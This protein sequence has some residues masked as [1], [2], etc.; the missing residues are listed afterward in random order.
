MG[1]DPADNERRL[2]AAFDAEFVKTKLMLE[3]FDVI[4][5]LYPQKG[6]NVP[7]SFRHLTTRGNGK[8]E[9]DPKRAE[10]LSWVPAIIKNHADPAVKR[11]DYLEGDGKINT[12][13][14]LEAHDFVVI[15][16]PKTNSRGLRVY[17]LV[18]AYHLDFEGT[19]AT[20]T[21][22]YERREGRPAA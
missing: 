10:R 4:L 5:S 13:L 20:Y 18:T 2:L 8:R 16:R 6:D 22:K 17:A 3:G 21:R 12:Y 15:A 14:W 7:A 9:F 19:R 1:N 11:W